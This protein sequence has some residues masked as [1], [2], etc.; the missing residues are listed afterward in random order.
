MY[1]YWYGYYLYPLHHTS[2]YSWG[3]TFIRTWR[4]PPHLKI[5]MSS[6][7]LPYWST[8]ASRWPI[9]HLVSLIRLVNVQCSLI[10]CCSSHVVVDLNIIYYTSTPFGSR[11]VNMNDLKYPQLAPQPIASLPNVLCPCT[12]E[13]FLGR[14]GHPF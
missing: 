13:K 11:K 2:S 9:V 3:I 1:L 8:Y 6:L 5:T 4:V 7:S 10:H 14:S 12:L